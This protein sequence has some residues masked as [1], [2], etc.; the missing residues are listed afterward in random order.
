ML[1]VLNRGNNS[2]AGTVEASSQSPVD[3]VEV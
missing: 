2:A 3:G 1:I